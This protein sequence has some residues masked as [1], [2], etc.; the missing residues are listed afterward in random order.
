MTNSTSDPGTSADA[1]R[2]VSVAPERLERWL[3]GFEQRHGEVDWDP[4]A[5][6]VRAR[7]PDGAV[8]VIA[9]P[10]PPLPI[11]TMPHTLVQHVQRS[12]RI[13]ALLVRK[14]G[15][16]VGVF[17]GRRLVASK[18]EKQYVQG[19]TKAGGWSQQRYARRRDNQARQ[20]VVDAADQVAAL[21]LPDSGLDAVVAG[22]DTALIA[23]VLADRRLEP[24]RGLVQPRVHP[25]PDPRL[26]VLEAFPDQF[27]AVSIT[28]NGL[29]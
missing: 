25:V 3:A 26:A 5:E 6:A 12:R 11:G 10:F 16:A 18:I 2:V 24:L 19:R 21:I 22:G 17:H 14:G 29:A 4:M 8:A 7:A 27:L 15:V 1:E 28:L 9:V 13:G 20:V 23:A